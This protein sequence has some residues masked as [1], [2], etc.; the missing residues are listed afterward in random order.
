MDHDLLHLYDD[1][2]IYREYYRL[3]IAILIEP[4][5][6]KQVLL[7][8]QLFSIVLEIK[9]RSEGKTHFAGHELKTA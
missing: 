2:D 5:E 3:K 7:K 6:I 9:K 1:E 4:R 8:I